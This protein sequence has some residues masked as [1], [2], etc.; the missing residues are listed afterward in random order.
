MFSGGRERLHWEQMGWITCSVLTKN[1]LDQI[2]WNNG[3]KLI[4]VN[5]RLFSR[6][7]PVQSQQEKTK[8]DFQ[9][10]FSWTVDF[11]QVLAY[12]V[13]PSQ[14]WQPVFTCSKLTIETPEQYIKP[15]QS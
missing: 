3:Q 13:E 2:H 12:R 10:M 7:K 6:S 14:W 11:E 5:Q 1:S 8:L 9:W 4:V 15:G